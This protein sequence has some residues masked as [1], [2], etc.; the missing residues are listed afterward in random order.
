MKGA[1]LGVRNYPRTIDFL[2]ILEHTTC[3]GHFLTLNQNLEMKF[4]ARKMTGVKWGST[5]IRGGIVA[6]DSMVC[7]V[8]GVVMR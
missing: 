3:N 6:A 7:V 8:I 2:V 5:K 1:S 4:L